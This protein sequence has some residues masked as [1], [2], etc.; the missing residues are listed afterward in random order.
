VALAA[1]TQNAYLQHLS[2]ELRRESTL[3]FRSH[4]YSAAAREAAIGHHLALADAIAKQHADEAAEIMAEH[5]RITESAIRGLADRVATEPDAGHE[6]PPT[7]A[8][9]GAASGERRP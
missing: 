9:A 2:S 7:P 5:I 4:P 6:P 3:G 1:A 8:S